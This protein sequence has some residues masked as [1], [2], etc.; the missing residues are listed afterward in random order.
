ME[1]APAV[2][3]RRRVR[4]AFVVPVIHGNQVACSCGGLMKLEEHLSL[5][6]PA[7][8]R[9]LLWRCR[10]NGDHLSQP[11]P[12]PIDIRLTLPEG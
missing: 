8:N 2:R 5:D 4:S 7:Q 1:A 12:F 3:R 10:I 6:L 11:F 9:S